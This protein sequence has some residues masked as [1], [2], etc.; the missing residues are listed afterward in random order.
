TSMGGTGNL[1]P[2]LTAAIAAASNSGMPE[3]SPTVT[4]DG[5]PSQRTVNSRSTASDGRLSGSL[6]GRVFATQSTNLVAQRKCMALCIARSWS[7]SVP[8][9]VIGGSAS[10]TAAA[11]GG[12]ATATAS[13]GA[14]P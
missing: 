10:A 5:V 3:L 1:L 6:G 7:P 14:A 2:P 12:G 13:A 9:V 8:G 11:P 4:C